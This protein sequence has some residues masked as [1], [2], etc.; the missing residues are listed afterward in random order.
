MSTLRKSGF[1][2]D[3]QGLRAIA[4]LLVLLFHAG[5]PGLKGGFVGVDIFFVLS[6]FLITGNLLEEAVA[7][8]TISIRDFYAK[9]I[10]RLLPASLL[11]LL[12]TLISSYCL[13][14]PVL[15]P[16]LVSDITATVLY[17]SNIAFAHQATDYFA[18]NATPSPVL[19][20]WSLG[21]E[22]QFYIFWPLI[23]LLLTKTRWR[24]SAAIR[25]FAVS[26]FVGSLSYAIWLLPQS[27]SWAFFS[28]PTRAWELALGAVLATFANQFRKLNDVVTW[29]LGTLGLAIVIASGL[30][31]RSASQFPGLPALFPTVGVALIILTGT[32]HRNTFSTNLLSPAP[33]QY[34]GKI[35]YSLYLWHWPIFVVPMIAVGHVLSW[36]IKSALLILTFIASALTEKFIERPFKAGLFTGLIPM[37]TF[38]IALS[39]MLLVIAASFGLRY[40]VLHGSTKTAAT[41]TPTSA[42]QSPT[43]STPST[44]TLVRTPTIDFPVPSNLSPSLFTAKQDKSINYA[45]HCHT[46]LNRLASK[47]ACLYGD[48][49]SQTT[50]ALFG[51]SHALAWFP[52]LDKL[53]KREHW[54]LFSQTMSSCN[55]ADIGAW[56]STLGKIMENCPIWRS[57]AIQ[58]IVARKPLFVLV[59]GT[60]NF[61]TLE[62]NGVVASRKRSYTIWESGMMRTI[63]TFKRA[64]IKVI[65]VSDVPFAKGDPV[66]C[67][68]AHPK[69]AIACANPVS[70]A[71]DANWLTAERAVARAE[72]ITLIE[73][74]L[75]VCPTDPCPAIINNILVYFDPS[76]MT[77]T[78]SQSLSGRLGTEIKK[79]LG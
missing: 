42:T 10:R 57:N 31:I 63:D 14:P 25:C 22:E 61:Q 23:V 59:G 56:S 58:N 7:T 30:A 45:D 35:S 54:K 50:V 32:H 2:R 71:I 13:L 72:A 21:V 19:H 52:A 70:N 47:A 68:S 53:S 43:T 33:M 6:G 8:S 36:P 64:G 44:T 5:L 48:T 18:A 17:V 67:L 11:V 74:Q 27:Q 62:P 29:I 41:Q 78:F 60:R 24:T 12:A 34:I 38:A 9:R 37:R 76:H 26:T 79:A 51:D 16:G 73:P 69:S 39:A 46:Q 4:V 49:R 65:L 28:L 40:Q 1:R 20:F 55:P 15:L 3:L 75:W 77:A 66:I